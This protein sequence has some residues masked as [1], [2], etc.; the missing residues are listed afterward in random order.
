MPI[1]RIR[2]HKAWG[3]PIELIAGEMTELNSWRYLAHENGPKPAMRFASFF[4]FADW[5]LVKIPASEKC[6]CFMMI[7]SKIRVSPR[8]AGLGWEAS[9]K[10]GGR[11]THLFNRHHFVETCRRCVY[12]HREAGRS[13][14]PRTDVHQENIG[15]TCIFSSKML[16]LSCWKF[17][18]SSSFWWL[19]S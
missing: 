1:I 3:K 12:A 10:Y 9:S 6:R 19:T 18:L 16:Q 7:L 4:F 17:Q 5:T 2:D 8:H 15:K 14:E 13:T 11:K